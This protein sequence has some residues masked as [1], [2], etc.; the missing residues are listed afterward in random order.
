MPPP[1]PPPSSTTTTD[2]GHGRLPR[3]TDSSMKGAREHFVNVLKGFIGSNYLSVPFAFTAAGMLLGPIAVCAVA[4]ISGAY[5]LIETTR[6]R[7]RL[8]TRT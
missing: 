2:D 7:P 8:L 5:S 6:P 4:A 3:V 1:R